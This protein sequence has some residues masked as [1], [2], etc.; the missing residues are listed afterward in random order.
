MGRGG[1]RRPSGRAGAGRA[2]WVW[3]TER[4]GAQRIEAAGAAWVVKSEME[5]NG[6]GRTGRGVAEQGGRGER[7]GRGRPNGE[8]AERGEAAT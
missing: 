2:V 6:T 3:R 1:K 7:R 8:R 4:D 5:R